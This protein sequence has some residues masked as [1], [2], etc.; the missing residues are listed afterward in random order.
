MTSN[1]DR[2]NWRPAAV[3]GFAVCVLLASSRAIGQVAVV[4]GAV[5]VFGQTNGT[6]GTH[7]IGGGAA[8]AGGRSQASGGTSSGLVGSTADISINSGPDGLG[9]YFVSVNGYVDAGYSCQGGP[10]ETSVFVSAHNIEI[11]LSDWYEYRFSSSDFNFSG[12]FF[13]SGTI[14]PGVYTIF[15]EVGRSRGLTFPSALLELTPTSAPGGGV[16]SPGGFDAP[17]APSRAS[18]ATARGGSPGV[19]FLSGRLHTRLGTAIDSWQP[20]NYSAEAKPSS[21]GP[22]GYAMPVGGG[23]GHANA[24][25]TITPVLGSHMMRIIADVAA[26]AGCSPEFG[27]VAAIVSTFNPN[28]PT[29]PATPLVLELDSD[30]T[31]TGSTGA[32]WLSVT[33]LTGAILGARWRAGTYRLDAALAIEAEPLRDSSLL[34]AVNLLFSPLPPCPADFNGDTTPGDIFDLFDF[35][36]ALDGGLDFNGDTTPADIFD[37]FDFLAVLDAGCP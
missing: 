3:S 34:G 29:A 12:G 25:A 19:R 9:G 6:R 13:G 35:L 27:G 17:D 23:L 31:V 8:A 7:S 10:T 22:V 1:I 4:D 2:R 28:Q 21:V 36:A 32:S 11:S 26:D 20:F 33:P 14:G 18:A 24:L 5:S 15:G 30:M 16:G 37:L